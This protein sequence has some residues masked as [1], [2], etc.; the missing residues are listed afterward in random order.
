MYHVKC[1]QQGEW[2]TLFS[3][4]DPTR[5]ARY[6]WERIHYG[7]N[8]ERVEIHDEDGCLE[9]TFDSTWENV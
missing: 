8:V 9:T 2:R 6:A 7:N 4:D 3:S 1:K 5:A